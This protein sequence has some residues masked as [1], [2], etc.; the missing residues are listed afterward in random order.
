MKKITRR[1]FAKY[2]GQSVI[3]L[4]FLRTIAS[5]RAF[6]AVPRRKLII[7][8]HPNG[9]DAGRFEQ[10][11]ALILNSNLAQRASFIKGVRLQSNGI[12]HGA[13][14]AILRA[15]TQESL[16]AFLEKQHGIQAL[17]LG[18]GLNPSNPSGVICHN[19]QG[20]A[21]RILLD[22]EEA[23]LNVFGQGLN[24]L[25]NYQQQEILA[26][27]KSLFDA[28]VGDARRLKQELGGM[29]PLFD[30]YLY[31]LNEVFKDVQKAK[32]GQQGDGLNPGSAEAAA[33]CTRTNP[34][35]GLNGNVEANFN[36]YLDATLGVAFQA[37]ACDAVQT[38][39]LQLAHSESGMAYNFPGGPV[40]DG[41]GFH[42]GVIHGQGKSPTY[43]A[44]IEW[45][46]GKVAGFA[47]K[48]TEGGDDILAQSAL[49]HTSNGGDAQ[50]HSLD[51]IPL[52]VY[53]ELGGTLNSGQTLTAP[54][55]TTHHALLNS[56]VQGMA[57]PGVTFGDASGSIP[58][59]ALS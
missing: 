53:G 47:Q 2:L 41:T 54:A 59:L 16:D 36:A 8:T 50:A 37:V 45:Y 18:L 15:N 46:F 22:P 14:Q 24:M 42:G 30:D 7:I 43:Q 28:C 6:G 4:P 21:G 19:E 25:P 3:A 5:E 34:A 11:R 39:V 33:Q 12:T 1:S 17:R 38:V 26:G 55:G 23:F 27:K 31:S 58:G 44:V 51:D 35:T 49:V 20:G 13:E 10:T 29:G 40:Q 48:L 32:Q 56:L 57:G 52:T 9:H